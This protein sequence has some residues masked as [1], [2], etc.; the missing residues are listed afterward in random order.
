MRNLLELVEWLHNYR[1]TKQTT[2]VRALCFTLLPTMVDI[3]ISKLLKVIIW[4]PYSLK[5]NNYLPNDIFFLKN[6]VL[7]YDEAFTNRRQNNSLSYFY[8]SDFQL[9]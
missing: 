9:D 1:K 4:H 6:F 8:L 7:K 3:L 2:H 5:S